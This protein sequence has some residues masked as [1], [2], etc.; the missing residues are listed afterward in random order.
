V[1]IINQQNGSTYQEASSILL[2]LCAIDQNSLQSQISMVSTYLRGLGESRQL[3]PFH[4]PDLLWRH[5]K[6][7]LWSALS[8]FPNC[9]ALI[10]DICVPIS[11]LPHVIEKIGKMLDSSSLVSAPII[12]H[13]GDGNV[14]TILLFRP[15][16]KREVDELND[17]MVSLAL[18]FDGTCTGEHGIGIGKRKFLKQELGENAVQTMKTIKHSLDPKNLLNPKK[19][20]PDNN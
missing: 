14:H 16:Q 12:A 5:R 10:T 7:A 20:I 15:H 4:N 18:E 17:R 2:E 19:I 6:E 8:A 3:K 13:A 11:N 9:E 1:R